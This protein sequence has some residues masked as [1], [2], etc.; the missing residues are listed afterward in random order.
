MGF[1]DKDFKLANSINLIP[2]KYLIKQAGNSI[3]VPVLEHIFTIMFKGG[4]E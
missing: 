2:N 3:V 1:D 4:E